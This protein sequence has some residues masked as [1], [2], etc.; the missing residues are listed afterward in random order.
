MK[1]RIAIYC[2]LTTFFSCTFIEKNN[3]HIY[4]ETSEN[5]TIIAVYHNS[6]MINKK[7]VNYNSIADKYDIVD[8]ITLK[9]NDTLIFEN[10][11]KES[12][13]YVYT[14]SERSKGINGLIISKSK[15]IVKENQLWNGK[16]Q[17]QDTVISNSFFC[18]PIKEN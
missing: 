18:M 4:Y 5:Q 14:K 7:T 6:K 2:F 11:E 9:I 1:V 17:K 15:Y 12:I 3:F 13:K 10:E 8:K 16:K